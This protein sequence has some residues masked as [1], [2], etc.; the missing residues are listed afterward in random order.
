MSI[1]FN[2]LKAHAL[3]LEKVLSSRAFLLPETNTYNWTNQV[4][5]SALARR[6]HLDIIDATETKKLWM[7]HLCVFPHTFDGAPIFGFDLVAGPN[8]VTGAFL[9]FSPVDPE[10]KFNQY[11]S[12]KV[13]RYEW[14][15]PR[16]LP[17]WAKKIFS[18]KMIAAGNINTEFELVEILDLSKELLV[19]YLDNIMYSRPPKSYDDLVREYNY[20]K[21][22][23]FYCQQQKQNPHTP[24]VLQALGFTEEMVHDFIHKDLFPELVE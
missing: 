6:M 4:Y 2:R 10:H 22:Q 19:H 8:K 21:Q 23:N 3:E 14:S 13:S 12:D 24:K 15:K 16:A 20:T 17:D 1:I 7:M 18:D 5:S 9:D 11:F